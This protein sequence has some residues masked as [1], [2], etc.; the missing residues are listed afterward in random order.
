VDGPLTVIGDVHGQAALL[1]RLLVRLRRRPDFEERWLVFAG[2][3]PDRGPDP[4]GVIDAVLALRRGHP[5]TTAVMG[6]HDL[7]LCGALRL[8]PAPAACHW[9]ARYVA[10]YDCASTFASYGVP[11]GDLPALAAAMPAE[12]KAFL[13]AL[14]WCVEHPQYLVVHAGLQPGVPYAA[15]L[16]ALWRRDFT[17]NRPPW[18]CDPLLARSPVPADCPQT[19]VNGHVRVAAV[20]FG[21][22]RVLVDTTGGTAGELSAVLLPERLVVTSASDTVSPP[23]ATTRINRK[24]QHQ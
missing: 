21:D 17:H 16:D 9:P 14:P 7:A 6:N 24:G 22:R 20:S 12:H 3:F 15:Q 1:R 8:V 18:L 4:R 19:V 2:D 13:S 5:R 11:H 10:S 23:A